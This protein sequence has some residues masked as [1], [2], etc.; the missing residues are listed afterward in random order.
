[1]VGTGVQRKC[2]GFMIGEDVECLSLKIV[3]ENE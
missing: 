3:S 1:M 2:K